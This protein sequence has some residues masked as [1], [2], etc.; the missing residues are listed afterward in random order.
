[1]LLFKAILKINT[2]KP[3][4]LKK[5]KNATIPIKMPGTVDGVNI[6]DI[7]ISD[8][9]IVPT[10]PN[11]IYITCLYMQP[12]TRFIELRSAAPIND[13]I[14]ATPKT[15]TALVAVNI[16]VISPSAYHQPIS[17]PKIIL[18]NTPKIFNIKNPYLKF[19]KPTPFFYY[20]TLYIIKDFE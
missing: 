12:V 20:Y 15:K 11:N 4:R 8:E 7:A 19:I 13:K 10:I 2:I 1:L 18:I 5:K 9:T 17:D 3:T 16:F 6:K 14:E